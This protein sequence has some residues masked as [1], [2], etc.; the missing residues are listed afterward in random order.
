MKGE[1]VKTFV[2]RD[3]STGTVRNPTCLAW[4]NNNSIVNGYN[5]LDCL[6]TWDLN[7]EKLV[8]SYRYSTELYSNT[9]RTQTNKIVVNSI[10]GLLVC[11]HEDNCVRAFDIASSSY[12][13]DSRKSGEEAVAC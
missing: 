7:Q 2:N 9:V 13:P 5:N 8:E 12:Y 11:A 10:M 3:K 4:L 1:I 6:S